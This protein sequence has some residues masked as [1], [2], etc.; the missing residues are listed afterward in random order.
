MQPSRF[1][2]SQAPSIWAQPERAASDEGTPWRLL[3]RVEPW[4]GQA[5]MVV[6]GLALLSVLVV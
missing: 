5:A 6:I 4:S 3:D 1:E 2:S